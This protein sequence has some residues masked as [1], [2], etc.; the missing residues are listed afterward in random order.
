MGSES[1]TWQLWSIVEYW[2]VGLLRVSVVGM[3]KRYLVP[4]ETSPASPKSPKSQVQ[5]CHD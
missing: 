2:H 3:D 4:G 5:N 1:I